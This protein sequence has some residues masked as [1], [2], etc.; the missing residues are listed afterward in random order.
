MEILTLQ[1]VGVVRELARRGEVLASDDGTTI[2]RRT[3]HRYPRGAMD[4]AVRQC[5]HGQ[6]DDSSTIRLETALPNLAGDIEVDPPF[7]GIHED[8]HRD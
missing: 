1:V 7:P 3:G 5:P 6:G 4:Q 2:Y 8:K